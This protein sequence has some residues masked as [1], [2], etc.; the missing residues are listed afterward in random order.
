MFFTAGSFAT[1][2]TLNTPQK[3]QL[4]FISTQSPSPFHLC[5]IRFVQKKIML[6]NSIFS[7]LLKIKSNIIKCLV[8]TL[9]FGFFEF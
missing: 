6:K 4:S 7:V 5:F 9:M 1:H 3:F 2:E 8:N